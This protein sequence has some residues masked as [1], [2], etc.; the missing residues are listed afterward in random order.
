MRPLLVIHITFLFV[1]ACV[2]CGAYW[3]AP[4]R[5][6]LQLEGT[7]LE[8]L[9]LK[10]VLYAIVGTVVVGSIGCAIVRNLGGLMLVWSSAIPFCFMSFL[11]M[12]MGLA[13]ANEDHQGVVQGLIRLIFADAFLGVVSLA[14]MSFVLRGMNPLVYVALAIDG[15]VLSLMGFIGVWGWIPVACAVVLYAFYVVTSRDYDDLFEVVSVR[16]HGGGSGYA[17]CTHL[18]SD[19]SHYQEG[20]SQGHP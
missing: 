3:L 12:G 2:F 20:S 11:N 14:V 5:Y 13:M 6:M 17:V 1:I 18:A 19:P 8:N 10:D 7:S 9:L 4:D 15:L 16:G